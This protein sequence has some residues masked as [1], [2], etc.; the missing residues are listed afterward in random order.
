MK[1]KTIQKFKKLKKNLI[2]AQRTNKAAVARAIFNKKALLVLCA[3]IKFFFSFL[4]F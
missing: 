4:N 3:A 1:L 2:A